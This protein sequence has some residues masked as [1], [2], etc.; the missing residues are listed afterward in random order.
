MRAA[1]A[2]ALLLPWWWLL[3]SARPAATSGSP[4]SAGSAGSA[5]LS[6]GGGADPYAAQRH[7]MVTEQVRKRGITKPEVLAAM[8]QVPRHLFL[9]ERIR[10]EAYEDRALSLGQS[11]TI[12][13]P[14]VV[15]LMTSL[16]DLKAGDTV[17]EVGTGTGYHAAVLSRIAH[18][19]YS[20]EIDPQVANQADRALS[21]MGYH[22]VKVWAGDGYLGLPDKA[23][24]DAILLSAAPPRI[25]RP[26]IE[27]L[28]VGGKM[29][30]P[31][32]GAIQDLQVITRTTN[33]IETR[34]VVPVRVSPMTGQAQDGQ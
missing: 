19:V 2:L 30:A 29:V 14:Y 17:L 6:S 3:A 28:R 33:G 34:T 1:R 21:A 20:I 13:Q 26:L 4:G 32:G 27:Q 11:R 7:A 9:P 15:A 22:N 18:Q 10:A 31:V 24:F 5:A 8:E 12:Y 25:P 16:L 23:P